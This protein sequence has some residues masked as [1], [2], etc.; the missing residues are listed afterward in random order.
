[1]PPSTAT[2]AAATSRRVNPQD[3]RWGVDDDLV[4][5]AGAGPLPDGPVLP[6]PLLPGQGEVL[7]DLAASLR[8]PFPGHL[9][10]TGLTGP[11][12]IALLADQI[13]RLLDAPATPRDLVYV[14]RP[15]HPDR[16]R[17]IELDAGQADAFRRDLLELR[18]ELRLA[19]PDDLSADASAWSAALARAFEPL[20]ARWPQAAAFFDELLPAVLDRADLFRPGVDP[21]RRGREGDT[22]ARDLL[23]AFQAQVFHRVFEGGQPD[24]RA[25]VVVAPTEPD[26]LLGGQLRPRRDAD[27]AGLPLRSGALHDA[28]GGVLVIDARDLFG[29]A[30]TLRAIR[31]LLRTGRL[32]PDDLRSTGVS[33][34]QPDPVPLDVQLVVVAWSSAHLAR[35]MS[36]PDLRA[37]ISTPVQLRPHAPLTG[38][39]VA[40]LG[41]WLAGQLADTASPDSPPRPLQAGAVAAVVEHLLREGGRGER[42]PLDLSAA[43]HL[44][45]GAAARAPQGAPVTRAHVEGER[46]DRLRRSRLAWDRSLDSIDRDVLHVQTEGRAV[47]QVNG[48]AVYRGSGF[49]FARPI[50]I[51]ATAGA[52]RGGLVDVERDAGLAGKL[53]NKGVRVFSGFLRGRFG[54]HQTLAIQASIG[55]E[56]HYGSIDGDSASLAEAAAL[57][58]AIS[59]IPLRQDRAVT[60]SIDQLGRVQSVGSVTT[61]VEGFFEVC[62]RRGLT[63]EQGVVVPA[64]NAVD[65]MLSADV[66]DALDAGRFHI[67]SADTV[68]HALAVL[69]EGIP[70]DDDTPQMEVGDPAAP[71]WPEDSFYGRVVAELLTLEQVMRRATK[72]PGAS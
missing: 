56:Q 7:H 22:E 9:L 20:R 63:G 46:A 34:L 54:R 23:L 17:L 51:T 68:E 57:L 35:W 39:L 10:V 21:S 33:P 60:G 43:L 29:R 36:D 55:I 69:I 26:R 48:L 52:G 58:S 15:R 38:E 71:E 65:L 45:R 72:G 53:H 32:A 31:T 19:W 8:R 13:R 18:D 3:L 44:I 42:V 27:P 30:A 1:M 61:K 4:L 14:S 16:P 2:T 50:R 47:G 66:L 67:W 6:G 59:R 62:Q 49:G 11:R 12:R 5:P 70:A 37:A 25:P 28:H 24:A 64:T 41:A 40:E